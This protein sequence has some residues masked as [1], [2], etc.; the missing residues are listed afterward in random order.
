[1]IP[2]FV[3]SSEDREQHSEI[4]LMN[5]GEV[6]KQYNGRGSKKIENGPVLVLRQIGKMT[7]RDEIFPYDS[8]E[9][10]EILISTMFRI[11]TCVFTHDGRPL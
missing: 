7:I 3:I 5:T 9:I 1:M 4:Y 10:W 2:I 6:I 8:P 11:D